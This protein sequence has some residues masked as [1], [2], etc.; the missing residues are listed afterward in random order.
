MKEK[1]L[2]KL[3]KR[4]INLQG[5][6]AEKISDPAGVAVKMASPNPFDGFGYTKNFNIVFES[7]LIKY[8][9]S[10]FN[11]NAIQPHQLQNLL[12]ISEITEFNSPPL[13]SV[14]TLGVWIPRE[15]FEIFV[16]DIKLINRLMTQGKKSI[17]GKELRCLSGN[18]Q[19][20]PIKKEVFDIS[21]L[22]ER[23]VYDL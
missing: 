11:F 19:G 5:G 15:S 1:D 2:N 4:N 18:K 20:I 13:L 23:V 7:K 14:I 17:L 12:K 22:K 21:Y 9:Y 3:I 6:W 10:A 16:F 8:A